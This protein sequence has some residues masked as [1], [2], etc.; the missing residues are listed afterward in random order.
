MYQSSPTI[1]KKKH[2][3]TRQKKQTYFYGEINNVNKRKKYLIFIRCHF[4]WIIFYDN[5]DVTEQFLLSYRI[6]KENLNKVLFRLNKISSSCIF[7]WKTAYLFK[8]IRCNAWGYNYIV[9]DSVLNTCF[10]R[11]EKLFLTTLP[12]LMCVCRTT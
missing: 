11:P 10:R 4:W 9:H 7:F 8:D 5:V 12:I 2:L 3:Y 6:Q 1:L